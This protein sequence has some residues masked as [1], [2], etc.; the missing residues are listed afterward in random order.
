MNSLSNQVERLLKSSKSK[1]TRQDVLEIVQCV[2]TVY[3]DQRERDL[4]ADN[5]DSDEDAVSVE[6]D[7]EGDYID[8]EGNIYDVET[9][10]LIGKKD[11]KTKEKTMYN[12]L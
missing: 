4:G 1:L 12:V 9:K 2:T 10:V 6:S 7:S 8:K 11:L 3:L 5:I